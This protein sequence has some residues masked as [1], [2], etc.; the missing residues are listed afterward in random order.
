MIR[1]DYK[2]TRKQ[3]VKVTTGIY[4][5]EVHDSGF[6]MIENGNVTLDNGYVT[7]DNGNVSPVSN[8][9]TAKSRNNEFI[10]RLFL[11]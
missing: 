5:P 9:L 3:A 11:I 7:L 2:K 4:D 8:N 6:A 10:R 1:I